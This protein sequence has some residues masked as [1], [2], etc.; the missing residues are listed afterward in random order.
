MLEIY[1]LRH[2]E[3]EWSKSGQH[4]G[5]TDIPL[6][7]EGVKQ[8]K[9][10][11]KALSGIEFD[12]VFCS[13]LLRAKQTCQQCGLLDG[14]VINSDL[15]EWDYG[16]YEGMT[17]HQIHNSDPSWTVFTKDPKNGETS[18]QVEARADRLIE[19]AKK[20][21]GKIA[22]FSSGHFSRA[23]AA[24][25][26][27]FPVSH[28]RYFKLSPATFSILSFEHDYQVIKSWNNVPY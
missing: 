18:M 11:K 5:L 19:E 14:A 7:D 13:P 25:W 12:K 6:I 24:R 16:D 23:L 10:L 27:G 1:I 8:A 28:G 26:L 2:G 17:T 3:T 22:F 9:A 20:Y 21:D 4:T 15:L